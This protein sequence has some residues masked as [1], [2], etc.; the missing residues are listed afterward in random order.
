MYTEFHFNAEL[1]W[2]T[3]KQVLDILAMMTNVKTIADPLPDPLPARDL[4]KCEDWRLMLLMDSSYFPADTHST[5]RFDADDDVEHGGT[6]FLCI[7]CNLKNYEHQIE[8]FLDWIGPYV[9]TGGVRECL[10]YYRYESDE[11]PTL[12]YASGDE[13]GAYRPLETIRA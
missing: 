7:R 2:D 3:P 1:K 13:T 12:I 4:F 5:L 10:G 8:K 6:W 9:E 11:D